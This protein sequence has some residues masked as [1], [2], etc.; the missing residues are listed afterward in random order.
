MN[1]RYPILPIHNNSE[2]SLTAIEKSILGNFIA[3][4]KPRNILEIGMY[5]GATTEII[6]KFILN[7]V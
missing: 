5:K 3:L 1:N 2:G 6:C 4:S 7:L